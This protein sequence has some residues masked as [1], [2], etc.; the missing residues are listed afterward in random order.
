MTC[1]IS[2]G[3]WR[4]W[5]PS[6]AAALR[7]G[8]SAP[9]QLPEDYAAFLSHCDG[10][11]AE[12]FWFAEAAPGALCYRVCRLLSVAEAEAKARKLPEGWWP[13]AVS[14]EGAVSCLRLELGEVWSTSQRGLEVTSLVRQS[15]SFTQY[16][17][18]TLKSFKNA[19]RGSELGKRA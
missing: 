4:V 14:R 7:P 15:C 10:Q 6:A 16:L 8:V 12:A 9:L 17:E 1:D 13:V 18:E 3:F 2:L 11:A 19:P 5:S